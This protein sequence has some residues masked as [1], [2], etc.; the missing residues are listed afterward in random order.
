MI[1]PVSLSSCSNKVFM[2]STYGMYCTQSFAVLDWWVTFSFL[3][4]SFD[5]VCLT[6]VYPIPLASWYFL[7]LNLCSCNCCSSLISSSLRIWFSR[8]LLS[9][10]KSTPFSP[11]NI[12]FFDFWKNDEISL[13]VKAASTKKCFLS[14]L[15][16]ALPEIICVTVFGPFTVST[17]FQGQILT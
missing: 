6:W 3:I 2:I 4:S 10:P 15:D 5:R 11:V 12:K 9:F 7:D 16:I 13:I 8:A 14:A 1:H 17:S